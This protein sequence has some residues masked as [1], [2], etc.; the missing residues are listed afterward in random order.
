MHS[1]EALSDDEVGAAAPQQPEASRPLLP[2]PVPVA[3]R[4][5][6]S[7]EKYRAIV[8]ED[9]DLRRG[10]RSLVDSNCFCSRKGKDTGT[11]CFAPFRQTDGFQIAVGIRKTLQSMN[12]NDADQK[13]EGHFTC[14]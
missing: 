12:K 6:T 14:G 1:I 4:P 8:A 13:P 3:P 7:S 2:P 9:I 11:S 10:L 5:N